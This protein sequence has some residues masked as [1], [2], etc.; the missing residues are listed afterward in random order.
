ML[1]CVLVFF[2]GG[3]VV[4]FSVFYFLGVSLFSAET[5]GMPLF[6]EALCSY[7]IEQAVTGDVS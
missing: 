2:P 7:N 1:C 4:L 5:G 3:T 6:S